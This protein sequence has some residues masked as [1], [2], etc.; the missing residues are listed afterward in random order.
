VEPSKE[1]RIGR[2]GLIKGAVGLAA[3][4]AVVGVPALALLDSGDSDS[5][6]AVE[7]S[8]VNGSHDP[9]VVYVNDA[10]N[11]EVVIMSGLQ[12]TVV[13]D[14]GLVGRLLSAGSV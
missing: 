2:R 7:M 8:P 5:Q 13:T 12:E 10:A 9:I 11:G 6:T 14:H 1:R 4:G 3:A